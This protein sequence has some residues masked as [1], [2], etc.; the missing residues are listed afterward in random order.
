MTQE[1]WEDVAIKRVTE[2][3]VAANLALV[4]MAGPLN[5]HKRLGEKLIELAEQYACEIVLKS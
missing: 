3:F 2:H 5:I 1:E 4:T